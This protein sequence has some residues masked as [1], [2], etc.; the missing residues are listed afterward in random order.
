MKKTTLLLGLVA[1]SGLA[2]A[3]NL[4]LGA[5]DD[6]VTLS[7]T[8]NGLGLGFTADY[9][10]NKH[11]DDSA[12]VGLEFAVPAG[13]L[14]VAAG[15]KAIYVDAD[16]YGSAAALGGRAALD[17]G[18]NFSLF[19]QGYFAPSG[20][21]SGSIREVNDVNAGLRWNPVPL[22]TVETG[23]RYF[24]VK[25][26]DAQRNRKLADGPYLGVGLQF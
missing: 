17:L 3:G 25:R 8:P 13:P 7:R 18:S 22:F 9:L 6:F 19:G 21:S 14:T 16:G 11:G 26:E 2:Q 24:D 5:G 20:A 10:N 1:I 23:Y 4:S 12:S 15:A